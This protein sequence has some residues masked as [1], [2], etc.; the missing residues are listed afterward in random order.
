MC[1]PRT[2]IK[3]ILEYDRILP[4]WQID[5]KKRVIIITKYGPR[6]FF[7]TLTT[8][9]PRATW[10]WRV[11]LCWPENC[12]VHLHPSR[13]KSKFSRNQIYFLPNPKEERQFFSVFIFL[14][15]VHIKTAVPISLTKS[16]FLKRIISK[17]RF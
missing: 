6:L 8:T 11:H 9:K 12:N 15:N 10:D 5:L 3:R 16:K 14:L 13:N 1:F 4:V 2:L 7:Y 17:Y